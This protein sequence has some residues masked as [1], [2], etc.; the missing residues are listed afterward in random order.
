[1]S[2]KSFH[3]N[4]KDEK[5]VHKNVSTSAIITY[6]IRPDSLDSLIYLKDHTSQSR[7]C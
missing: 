3:K 6:M 4:S 7:A 1:M 2:W 5:N